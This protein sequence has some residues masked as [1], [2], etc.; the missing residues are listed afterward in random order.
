[1]QRQS[2]LAFKKKMWS[3]QI[4]LF[5]EIWSKLDRLFYLKEYGLN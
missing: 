4:F 1:M 5:E 2:P 3:R